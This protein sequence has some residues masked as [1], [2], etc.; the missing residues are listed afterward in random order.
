MHK[1]NPP[2]GPHSTIASQPLLY[3]VTSYVPMMNANYDNN[4][5][6]NDIAVAKLGAFSKYPPLRVQTPELAAL[7][8]PGQPVTIVGWGCTV[9][10]AFWSACI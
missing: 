2:P 3:E 4:S 8:E 6:L 5:A 9:R 7:S 1:P 10:A